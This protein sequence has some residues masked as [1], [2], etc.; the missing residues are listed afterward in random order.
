LNSASET[1]PVISLVAE[2]A[3]LAAPAE[4]FAV[5]WGAAFD[6]VREHETVL[7]KSRNAGRAARNGMGL[8]YCL[9]QSSAAR[10]SVSH[11]SGLGFGMGVY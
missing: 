5:A 1:A 10:R 9:S 11:G 4:A 8:F 2:G 6:E 3:A 7:T